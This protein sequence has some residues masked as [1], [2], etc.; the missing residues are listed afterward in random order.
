MDL[1]AEPFV[2]R[3]GGRVV[4]RRVDR[5]AAG[6]VEAVGAEGVA[7]ERVRGRVCGVGRG[8][9]GD[10]ADPEGRAVDAVQRRLP[11]LHVQGR[12]IV[13]LARPVAGRE[14]DDG[15][16]ESDGCKD[17]GYQGA[18]EACYPGHDCGNLGAE[19]GRKG[20]DKEFEAWEGRQ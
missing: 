14:S 17:E 2:A 4:L 6:P 13:L 8:G 5:L 12:V 20:G 16:G 18:D 7:V 9:S 1:L 19:M 3:V 10:L 11:V 15:E